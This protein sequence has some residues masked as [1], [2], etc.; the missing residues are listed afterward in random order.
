MRQIKMTVAGVLLAAALV[1]GAVP[2]PTGLA[3]A[4]DRAPTTLRTGSFLLDP[5]ALA[6]KLTMEAE[7]RG[8]PLGGL[9]MGLQGKEL[10]FSAGGFPICKAVTDLIGQARCSALSGGLGVLLALLTSQARVDFAGDATFQ[11]SSAAVPAIGP[12]LS[13]GPIL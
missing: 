7:L 13:Q 11:P 6:L 10:V 1:V 5:G 12:S 4:D 8:P 2:G 9:P 3:S